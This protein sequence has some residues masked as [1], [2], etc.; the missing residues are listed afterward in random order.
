MDEDL[1]GRRNFCEDFDEGKNDRVFW[2]ALSITDLG[3][4]VVFGNTCPEAR[5][6]DKSLHRRK[7]QV[8]KCAEDGMSGKLTD[9]AERG[10][11]L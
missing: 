2:T 10:T 11:V 4:E 3:L 1:L 5:L 6:G 9:Y 8:S 7:T